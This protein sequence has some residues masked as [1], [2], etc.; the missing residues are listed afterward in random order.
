MVNLRQSNPRGVRL[1]AISVT[2][3]PTVSEGLNVQKTDIQPLLGWVNSVGIVD[4]VTAPLPGML[5]HGLTTFSP[6]GTFNLR[7]LNDVILSG[8]ILLQLNLGCSYIS[9]I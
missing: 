8:L 6:S 5:C 3:Q 2:Q 9:H 7:N 1:G 4:S